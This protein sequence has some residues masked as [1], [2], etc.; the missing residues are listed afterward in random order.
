MDDPYRA[1]SRVSTLR[2]TST[3]INQPDS[4][5]TDAN[6]QGQITTES[7]ETVENHTLHNR[8]SRDE[9]EPQSSNPLFD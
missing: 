4:N 3:P 9:L 1:R 7:A 5:K 2:Q 6:D 8:F